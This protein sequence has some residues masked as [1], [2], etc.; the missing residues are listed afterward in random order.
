MSRI[1]KENNKKKFEEFQK[2][3]DVV[4]SFK[5]NSKKF[6]QTRFSSLLVMCNA[7]NFFLHVHPEEE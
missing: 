4:P 7:N 3:A 5:Q 2:R 1:P 6:S